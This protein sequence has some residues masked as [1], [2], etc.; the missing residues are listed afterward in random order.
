MKNLAKLFFLLLVFNF[1]ACAN[2]KEI[3]EFETTLQNSNINFWYD[4]N[5]NN[6]YLERLRSL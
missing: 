1:F 3:L 2:K 4:Q 6:E 5:E